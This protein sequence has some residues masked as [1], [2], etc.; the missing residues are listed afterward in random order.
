M[1]KI[2]KKISKSNYKFLKIVGVLV[3]FGIVV[4]IL[5]MYFY[6]KEDFAT[7]VTDERTTKL[8]VPPPNVQLP[9]I[10]VESN[11]PQGIPRFIEGSNLGIPVGRPVGGPPPGSTNYEISETVNNIKKLEAKKNTLPSDLNSIIVSINKIN[12]AMD[13]DIATLKTLNTDNLKKLKNKM[14]L[15]GNYTILI[16]DMRMKYE[17]LFTP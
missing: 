2:I 10:L 3:L 1:S 5:Y 11:M 17:A 7:N 8:G 14:K 12:N 6:K 4:Y 13:K 9:T 16:K 15:G